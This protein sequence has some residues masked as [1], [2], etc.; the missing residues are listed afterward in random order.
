MPATSG[1]NIDNNNLVVLDFTDKTY[2]ILLRLVLKI[3]M[4]DHLFI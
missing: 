1:N 2:C 4:M 3:K